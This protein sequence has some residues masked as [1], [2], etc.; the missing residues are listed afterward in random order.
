MSKGN[1]ERV[2][3]GRYLD[4]HTMKGIRNCDLRKKLSKFDAESLRKSFTKLWLYSVLSAEVSAYFIGADQVGQFVF[5][6]Q[7]DHN[8]QLMSYSSAL[9]LTK[10]EA[11]LSSFSYLQRYASKNAS[12]ISAVSG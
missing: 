2:W 4:R 12:I 6:N 1:H 9:Y 10:K 3:I 5:D 8:N 7:L 11:K